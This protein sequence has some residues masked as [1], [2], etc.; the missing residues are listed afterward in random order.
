V[1]I[2]TPFVIGATN[3][4]AVDSRTSDIQ[5]AA[6][7]DNGRNVTINMGSSSNAISTSVLDIIKNKN[8]SLILDYGA[9]GKI[10]VNGRAINAENGTANLNLNLQRSAA[11]TTMLADY[12][13]PKAAIDGVSPLP[14]QQLKIGSGA[15]V[16][17]EGTVLV[18]LD[19]VNAG[20][21]AILARFNSTANQFEI[22]GTA[23]IAANGE[24]T[25]PFDRTGDYVVIIQKTGDVNGDNKV[26]TADALEAL[27][28]AI[29]IVD[30]D[31]FQ[32]HVV[33]TRRDETVTTADALQILRFAVGLINSI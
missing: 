25:I 7:D 10:T 17:V 20:R 24:A 27:R 32:M 5:S 26:D 9:T 33:N 8:V 16:A 1:R 18:N 13:I 30:F 11:T 2:S 29:G 4:A 19:T 15:S 14:A 6:S 28:K 31:P 21:N 12:T 22:A 23:V 3:T